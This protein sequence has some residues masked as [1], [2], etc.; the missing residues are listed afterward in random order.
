MVPADTC[1]TD[2]AYSSTGWSPPLDLGFL[3]GGFL[4]LAGFGFAGLDLA[5][6]E[7]TAVI[8]P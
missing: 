8:I 7:D 6:L 1:A 5:V 2:W 3:T 4:G